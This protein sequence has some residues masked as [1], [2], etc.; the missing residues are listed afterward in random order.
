[1][2]T[3]LALAGCEALSGCAVAPPPYGSAG[4]HVLPSQA[5]DSS[6]TAMNP[7]SGLSPREATQ[8]VLIQNLLESGKPYAALAHL[9]ASRM[10]G[11]SVDYVRAQILRRIGREQEARSLYSSLLKT[12]LSGVGQHGLG[13]VDADAGRL[14]AAVRHLREAR[15]ALPADAG[16][17]N[18]LGYVLLLDGHYRKAQQQFLTALDLS[19]GK[20][21]AA[22]NLAL[23]LLLN[24]ETDRAGQVASLY[25]I[26]AEKLQTLREQ[27][28][29]MHARLGAAPV[30]NPS[31]QGE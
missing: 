30:V 11:N 29:Q 7:C 19:P 12:C 18:D 9:D 14:D 10:K 1:M 31:L 13:L 15:L 8:L 16:I 24:G 2:L 17:R 22:V 26:S 23:A 6:A 5:A 25:D 20:R 28:R 27:A 4:A 3:A 21:K